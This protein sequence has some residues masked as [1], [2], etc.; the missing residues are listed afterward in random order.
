MRPVAPLGVECNKAA[1]EISRASNQ[2]APQFILVERLMESVVNDA[3]RP[4][5]RP[6]GKASLD[7]PRAA[8]WRSAF[9]GWVRMSLS[10][11]SSRSSSVA[12]T[13]RRP[14]NSG[15]RPYLSKSSGSSGRER[16]SCGRRMERRKEER[17]NIGIARVSSFNKKSEPKVRLLRQAVFASSDSFWLLPAI[18]LT[19]RL[20]F[21]TAAR[22]HLENP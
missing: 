12:M 17:R 20:L 1:S 15:I 8:G 10:D 19:A 22:A 9:L 2:D 6:R 16:I 18:P 4:P 21:H 11:A 3:P 14:T 5:A 13:G 7:R